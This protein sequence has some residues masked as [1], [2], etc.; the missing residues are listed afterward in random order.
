MEEGAIAEYCMSLS[1]V[2]QQ[3]FLSRPLVILPRCEP[4]EARVRAVMVVVVAPCRDQMAWRR[5]G[6]RCSWGAVVDSGL[7]GDLPGCAA[8]SGPSGLRRFSLLTGSLQGILRI[9]GRFRSL[10]PQIH[11]S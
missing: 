1:D 4:V 8:S 7:E 6:N 9:W 10:G 11:T 5:V 2:Q 3:R